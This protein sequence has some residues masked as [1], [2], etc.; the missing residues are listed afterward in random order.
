MF[1]GNLIRSHYRRPETKLYININLPKSRFGN[2][3]YT[4]SPPLWGYNRFVPAPNNVI[5]VAVMSESL[6]PK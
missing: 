4:L 3:V 5:D 1:F 2:I 6:A